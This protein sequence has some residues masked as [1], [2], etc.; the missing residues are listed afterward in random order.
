MILFHPARLTDRW[1]EARLR[2]R[3]RRTL[4]V[5]P[6]RAFQPGAM[7]KGRLGSLAVSHRLGYSAGRTGDDT[8]LGPQLFTKRAL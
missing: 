4:M 8:P 7:G 5:D 1:S 3:G 6:H 2:G